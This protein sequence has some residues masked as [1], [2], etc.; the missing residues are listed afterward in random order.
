MEFLY[1][2]IR[3]MTLGR[4][5]VILSVFAMVLAFALTFSLS[6]A[7]RDRAVHDLAKED[8]RQTSQL[9]F[10]S[11]YSAM[12]KGWSKQD[13]NESIERLNHQF[14]EL[15]I[16]VFRGEK[17][18]KQF[19]AMPHEDTVVA[20]DASLRKALAD[21]EEILLFPHVDEIR[22]LYPLRAEEECLACHTQSHVGA[23][24]GV[25]DIVYPVKNLKVSFSS[26]LNSMLV[27][28]LAI[29]GFV[30]IVL[31]FK[32]RYLFVLPIAKLVGVMREISVDMDLTR[33]VKSDIPLL[34]L[35]SL[36]E[37]FNGLLKTVHEYNARLEELSTHD[38]LTDL[39]NRRKF[40][41]F[42]HYEL[43][44]SMRHQRSFSVIM[45]DL[46]NFKYI[47]DT[48]GHP[49]G[50]LVLKELSLL[51]STC[52][53]KGDVLA[54]LGGDEFAI[55]LPETEPGNG[56]RVAN[57]LLQSLQDKE[58]ELPVGKVRCTASFSLVSYPEDGATEG[59]IY[60]A[61]DVVLYKAKSHGKNQ[62]MTAEC[63]E[64]RSMMNVFRQGEFLRNALREGR[65]EA[66]LQPIVNLSDGSIKAYEVLARI[67][68][69]EV[70][71][72][73]GEFVEVAEKLGMAQELDSVV[74]RKG[75]S[76]YA[77]IARK[78]P[79]AK[80]FFNLFPRSFNDIDWVRAIPAMAREAGAPCESIVLELTEREALPNLSQV[81]ALIEELKGTG[82]KIALDD[83]G[84]GFSSFM[85]LKYLPVDYV[86][87]E[88]SFVQQIVNDPRDRVMVEHINS[89]AHQFG[90]KTIAEFVED[91]ETARMLAEIGVDSAQGYHFG[92]PASP[93]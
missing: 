25:I 87:I 34:E 60:S 84:S 39:Y 1:R 81:R 82:I 69:G 28:T 2:M 64:D 3:H 71:V 7:M 20:G 32:L 49:V 48:F 36:A 27:Y 42:L 78:Y 67:R 89:M 18:T 74:F 40:E 77:A 47:N 43:I 79:D 63:E 38:P 14:P 53:R 13:I 16:R 52:L 6:G 90:L 80:L 35:R 29:I 12:R 33:R 24:H 65:V 93:D 51:L 5:L 73:A 57:K 61:M 10:Q 72:P 54:R 46:D 23:V 91:E 19:G 88:G 22:Y 17:V 70:I 66:F 15:Q 68:D 26:V 75:L 58:F 30:F 76:H 45:V 92:R 9:V 44:R 8:A 85:Y 41:D 21:G 37:Y 86:K 62:V 59:E 50:D 56:M 31:Y 83:F 55:L 4:L 11:L